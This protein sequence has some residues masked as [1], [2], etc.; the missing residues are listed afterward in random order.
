MFSNQDKSGAIRA[1]PKNNSTEVERLMPAAAADLAVPVGLLWVV[2]VGLIGADAGPDA[3]DRGFMFTKFPFEDV[4]WGLAS[5]AAGTVTDMT[6][7][8]FDVLAQRQVGAL[9]RIM[10]PVMPM[11]AALVYVTV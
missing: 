4:V 8:P 9:V 10:S 6:W 5:G 7:A 1:S 3:V 2:L 11:P